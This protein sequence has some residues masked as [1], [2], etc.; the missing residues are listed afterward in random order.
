MGGTVERVMPSFRHGSVEI[1]YLDEGSGEPVVLVHGFASNKEVN[2][3]APGWVTALTRAG[4]RAIALDNRAMVNR[5]SSTTR[6]T[7]TAPRWRRM[8]GR[9]S[10]IS[11]SS[12][13]M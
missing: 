10:I 12:A 1:F 11:P 7:I 6:L 2:W 5:P 4:R 3:V 13:P 8:C 9:C